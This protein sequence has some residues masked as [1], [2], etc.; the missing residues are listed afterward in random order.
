VVNKRDCARRAN[1]RSAAKPPP[2]RKPAGAGARKPGLL[3]LKDLPEFFE[4]VG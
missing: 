1:E 4:G 3:D 2:Q